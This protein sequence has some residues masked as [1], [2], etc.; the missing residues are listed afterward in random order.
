KKTSLKPVLYGP[1]KTWSK[2]VPTTSASS[3]KSIGGNKVPL[4]VPTAP[5]DNISFHYEDH[6]S[7]WKCVYN[8][9]L[10]LERELGKEALEC[11]EIVDLIKEAGLLKTVW[12]MRDYY[13]KLVKEFL[14]CD[15]LLS[16]E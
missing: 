6:V 12:G 10:A 5:I 8:R 4:N 1:K 2:D 7:Q 13:D 14:D 9:R 3:R 11:H 16:K 15:D